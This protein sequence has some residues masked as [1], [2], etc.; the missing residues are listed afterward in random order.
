MLPPE[1][2]GAILTA[3]IIGVEFVRLDLLVS[4]QQCCQLQ[5]SWWRFVH[6]SPPDLSR[7]S[8]PQGEAQVVPAWSPTFCGASRGTAGREGL[9]PVRLAPF[10]RGCGLA[11][12]ISTV[13]SRS[14]RSSGVASSTWPAKARRRS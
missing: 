12:G 13:P 8:P 5:V 4:G 7:F 9:P 14:C 6:D 2:V 11:G 3:E 10:L 1:N